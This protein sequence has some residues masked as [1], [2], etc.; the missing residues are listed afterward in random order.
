[1]TSLPGADVLDRLDRERAV[2]LCTLRPGGSPHLTPVWFLFVVGEWWICTAER[3]VKVR[4]VLADSRVS[5]ALP[6]PCAPVVAEGVATVVRPPFRPDIVAGFRDRYA[7]WDI[8]A[9]GPDGPYVL[10]RVGVTRWLLSGRAR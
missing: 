6:D 7:G 8:S 3:N 4:N 2:W 10:L 5:L 9:D 1:M